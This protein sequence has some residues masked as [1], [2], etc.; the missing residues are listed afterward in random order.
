MTF[1][2][3]GR[4]VRGVF[5]QDPAR[6][7]KLFARGAFRLRALGPAGF[8]HPEVGVHD[9]VELVEHADRL[10]AEV[11]AH[12]SDVGRAHV[13]RDLRDRPGMAVVRAQGLAPP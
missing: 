6:L 7:L 12:A 11:P 4:V 5:E 3:F 2:L 1:G 9:D 10:V 8:V 13:D